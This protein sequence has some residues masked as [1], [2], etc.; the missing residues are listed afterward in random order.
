MCKTLFINTDNS[1]GTAG[2]SPPLA[3]NQKLRASRALSSKKMRPSEGSMFF[4]LNG[5]SLM[6]AHPPPFQENLRIL[7]PSIHFLRVKNVVRV[8]TLRGLEGTRDM[9]D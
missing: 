2:G 9:A 4:H 7:F 1:D 6:K 8:G 5:S 3:C